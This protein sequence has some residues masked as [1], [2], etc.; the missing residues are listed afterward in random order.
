MNL[1]WTFVLFTH[2]GVTHG[3][4]GIPAWVIPVVTP[5][6]VNNTNVHSKF[7]LISLFSKIHSLKSEHIHSFLFREY[8][9]IISVRTRHVLKTNDT[10]LHDW[11]IDIFTNVSQ[12]YG[13]FFLRDLV[14]SHFI[15]LY[16]YRVSQKKWNGGFS[17]PCI[18][19]VVYF[20]TSLDK[21]SSAEEN[22]T[23]IIKFGSV[24]F[25]L[26]PFLE[27]Q[28]FSN[29]AGFLRRM[30][31]IPYG[32]LCKP[33]DP[34]QQKIQLAQWARAMQNET[35]PCQASFPHTTQLFLLSPSPYRHNN[36]LLTMRWQFCFKTAKTSSRKM[37]ISLKV[38][39]SSR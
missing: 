16:L 22:D 39:K 9:Y 38:A 11:T 18:L 20:L 30:R 35:Q 12:I 10:N 1:E 7:T 14:T 33:V 37:V 24:L 6:W 13:Y 25:I 31:R 36:E 5:K 17:V 21:A 2:F 26:R 23:K 32:V 27:M 34:C 28:S 4:L 19:K 15:N 29:F 3:S 8:A